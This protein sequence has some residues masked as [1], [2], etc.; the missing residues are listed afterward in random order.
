M[1]MRYRKIVS[2]FALAAALTALP[3]FAQ[4]PAA[5]A[6]VDTEQLKQALTK[7]RRE[8]FSAGMGSLSAP[9]LEKFWAIY[10]EY[11]KER[12]AIIDQRMGLLKDY[13]TKYKTMQPEDATGWVDKLAKIGT[14]E[15]TLRKKYADQIGKQ[16][17]PAAAARFWQ[18][19]DYITS[20]AKIDVM[21]NIP[22]VKAN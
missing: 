20:A 21:D 6:G 1:N 13:A 4:A 14:D 7:G 2:C 10:G 3:A 22:L 19:D 16:I 11:E 15:I 12:T 5:S 18:I 9:N 8:L 17:S